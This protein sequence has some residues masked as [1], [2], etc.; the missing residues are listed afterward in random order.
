MVSMVRN[1]LSPRAVARELRVAL[2]TVQRWVARAKDDVL[3]RVDWSDRPVGCRVSA[4]RTKP[5]IESRVLKARRQ[6]K[7]KSDLGEY[8]AAAIQRELKR[9]G[10]REAPAIRTIG[11]ILA[12]NGALDGRRRMRYKSPPPG[13][14]LS[15]LADKRV[16]LDSF[17]AI[18]DLVMRG[19][20]DVNVLTGVSLY[21]GLCAA[22]P[23]ERMTAKYTVD[24]LLS[25]WRTFGLPAYAKFDN[26]TI[27]QGA[28]QWPDSFGRVTRLCLSLQVTPVFAPPLSR[29]FQADIEAFNRRWQDAVWARFK[30]RDRVSLLDRSDR[31]VAAHRDRHAVRIE[32]APS[33][34]PFP[35][36]WRLNLQGRLQGTVIFLRVTN[37]KGEATLLGRDVK[38]SEIWCN[39]LVRVEVDLT[40][41][42]IRIFALRRKEPGK[43]VLLSTHTYKPP[44]TR[45]RE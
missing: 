40:K 4:K 39:R 11:R 26:G 28:H 27:F 34:R 5:R 33:R 10:E 14:Y 25:H 37:A 19:G 44:Q 36:N 2:S 16:E 29:G 20:R 1:G 17:D 38:A 7:T 3:D 22:W 6:L 15:D 18:E 30:F 12:R 9:Q 32:D 45:F 24:C 43:H 42:Q 35:R 31:F 41:E 13:W 8:G 23:T 21:G